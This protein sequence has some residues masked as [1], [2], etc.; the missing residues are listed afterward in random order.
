MAS[1][2]TPNSVHVHENT[3][4]RLRMR[5][6]LS[7]PPEYR[8]CS[9][10]C[11]ALCTE[12]LRTARIRHRTPPAPDRQDDAAKR[13]IPAR[14]ERGGCRI[15]RAVRHAALPPARVVAARVFFVLSRTRF[16][17]KEASYVVEFYIKLLRSATGQRNKRSIRVL[18]GALHTDD[19]RAVRQNSFSATTSI[20]AHA[21]S[22]I[23]RASAS[24]RA[25][26]VA[27]PPPPARFHAP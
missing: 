10:A 6:V 27:T 14:E 18:R 1:K 3:D 19:R 23:Q 16:G 26:S 25:S 21:S 15:G 7:K 9:A 5:S 4:T 24:V 11:G 8:T 13:C 17:G 2:G 22:L 20:L 12:R